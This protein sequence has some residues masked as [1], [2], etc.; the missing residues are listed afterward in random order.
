MSENVKHHMRRRCLRKKLLRTIIIHTQCSHNDSTES[1]E[2]GG[3]RI[4]HT[5]REK[6]FKYYSNVKKESSWKT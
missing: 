5:G 4:M 1:D 6:P 2:L 3:T